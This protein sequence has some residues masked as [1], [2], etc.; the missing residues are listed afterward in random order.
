[1]DNNCSFEESEIEEDEPLNKRIKKMADS[2]EFMKMKADLE[3]KTRE[4]DELRLEMDKMK[5]L[6][7]KNAYALN[8][9]IDQYK[10]MCFI[11]SA[12]YAAKVLKSAMRER[13]NKNKDFFEPYQLLK[14]CKQVNAKTCARY[15]QG[16]PCYDQ[17]HVSQRLERRQ[18]Q[19]TSAEPLSKKKWT[20]QE[21]LR[22]HCCVLCLE[23]LEI[24]SGHPLVRCPWIR[25]QTWLKIE[26]TVVVKMDHE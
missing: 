15:N 3:R 17:W 16:A 2:E 20:N 24:I 8:F 7:A 21:E 19:S 12:V 13:M 23:S 11:D 4:M 18:D 6:A 22:L 9:N 5:S 25:E 26:K 14:G 1:L 10:Q